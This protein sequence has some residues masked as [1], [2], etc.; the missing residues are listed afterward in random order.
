MSHD[1]HPHRQVAGIRR[2]R[3]KSQRPCDLCRARKVLCNIPD[4]TRPCQLCDRTGRDCTFVGNPNKK[5]RDSRTRRL[6]SDGGGGTPIVV[7]QPLAQDVGVYEALRMPDEIQSAGIDTGLDLTPL[8]GTVSQSIFS[9]GGGINWDISFD[10]GIDGSDQPFDFFANGE[11][12]NLEP[13]DDPTP[14][15]YGEIP[16][17][18]PG[19]SADLPA[20]PTALFERLS[21]D[22]R[23]DHSTSLIGFSNESD[24]FS[25]NHFPY[26]SSDEVDFYRVAYRRQQHAFPANPPI[27][28]LQSQT[29]TAI[30]SQKIVDKCMSSLGDREH[31]EK[32][33]DRETGVALVK[34]Y[35][36]F[37]FEDLPI[38]SR[39]LIFEDLNK[40][41]AEASTGLLAGVYALALP[42]TPWDEKLCLDSAY[43]KPDVNDL[44]QVSYT[45]L[46][47]ELHFP[48]LSTIQIFILLLNH[49]PFDVVVVENPFVWS[50]AASMLA[51]AQSLGLN[52]NPSG[53]KL[54]AWEVRLR[55]RLWW[56]VYV[57][58]TWRAVTHG[59][60]S[61]IS[62][63]DWDVSPL[64]S[65]DFTIDPTASIP[66]NI[67]DQSL[68]YF[69]R[70]CSLTEITSAICRQ[71]FSLRAASRP[72]IL[73]SLLEQAR[74]PRQ[75]LLK[76]LEDLPESLALR[77]EPSDSDADD[78]V[79]SHRSLYV[80]YYTTHI[81]VLRALLRP[82]IDSDTQL[83]HI[84]SSVETVLQACRGLIQT[85]IKFIRGL[86]ARH[87]SA[88]WPAYTR[89][90]LAYPGLFC[91]MLCLQKR[92]PD[93]TA[94]DQNLLATWR[95][96][97]RTRMQS[98]P[99]LRFAIVK[100]DAIYWKK[101]YQDKN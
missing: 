75:Q 92:Q 61:M 63:D 3:S 35:F 77:P 64:T 4:P 101:L 27:H 56:A 16:T 32:L 19:K 12:P 29:G 71:F 31:L 2:Y 51:M 58:Y 65:A 88:F 1:E 96:T 74:G 49:T 62:D 20:S 97:L 10:H 41:V 84:Q 9:P 34:L 25:L 39:S 89:N 94:Y 93:M 47:K 68:D 15:D 98:W 72:Q 78:S 38:L 14:S 28:F 70:L 13:L 40:F 5:P 42:F 17:L 44:W 33:V 18:T 60:S 26:S 91:Y 50:L 57:E 67:R 43:F 45:C 80:A 90:C 52:V 59:R 8:D 24:P 6:D 23:P 87:Q 73:D 48:R 53:W 95:K 21:F 22:Q 83:T 7:P 69:I 36:R 37:V 30:E 66:E 99:F 79:K 76:W 85:V 11:L 54:P 55:R 81:L 86:D 100:V 82:I 46:Q